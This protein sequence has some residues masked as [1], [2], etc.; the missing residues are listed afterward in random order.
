MAS[1]NEHEAGE[2]GI[3]LRTELATHRNRLDSFHARIEECGFRLLLS[4]LQAFHATGIT[5]KD[6]QA[7]GDAAIF[8]TGYRTGKK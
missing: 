7:I 2:N 1:F 4:D 8:Y 3:R 5:E 6:I